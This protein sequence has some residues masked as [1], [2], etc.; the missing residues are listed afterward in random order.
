ML[1]GD[2]AFGRL[3]GASNI[4]QGIDIRYNVLASY[5]V[6]MNISGNLGSW[7]ISVKQ[8]NGPVSIGGAM[9]GPISCDGISAGGS[10][11]IAGQVPPNW[12]INTS[13]AMSGELFAYGPFL[14]ACNF[15][16][17]TG[18]LD[19][20]STASGPINIESGDCGGLILLRDRIPAT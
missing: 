4:I 15:G 8:I 18:T 17:L 7:G 20:R 12:S 14:G 1:R 5:L 6:G 3:A 2:P 11:A 19:F 10:I 16:S 9:N 13:S